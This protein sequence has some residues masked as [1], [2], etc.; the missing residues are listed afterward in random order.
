MSNIRVR[1]L[2][3]WVMPDASRG[4]ALLF[5]EEACNKLD[6]LYPGAVVATYVESNPPRDE[7]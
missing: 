7:I 1:I 5:S 4:G 3:E 6:A 2:L